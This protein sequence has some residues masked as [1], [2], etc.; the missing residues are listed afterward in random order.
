M[1]YTRHVKNRQQYKNDYR[2][3]APW[4]DYVHRAGSDRVYVHFTPEFTA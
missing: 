3:R 1:M 4:G 2:E